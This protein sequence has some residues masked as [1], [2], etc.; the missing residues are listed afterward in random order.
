MRDIIH[1]YSTILIASSI[2]ANDLFNKR[3]KMRKSLVK[4]PRVVKTVTKVVTGWP[5]TTKVG[6]FGVEDYKESMGH[7]KNMVLCLY[8]KREGE[9]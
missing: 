2:H 9:R 4:L 1:D 5:S 6:I 8:P 3:L 7:V